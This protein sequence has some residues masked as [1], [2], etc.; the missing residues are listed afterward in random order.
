[1]STQTDVPDAHRDIG[2]RWNL[3]KLQSR[4]YILTSAT[5]TRG[6]QYKVLCGIRSGQLREDDLYQLM[7]RTMDS[8][9]ITTLETVLSLVA[10]QLI[11]PIDLKQDLGSADAEL[12]E[13]SNSAGGRPANP[14]E[15]SPA[16]SESSQ[17]VPI[18][19]LEVLESASERLDVTV[20]SAASLNPQTDYWISRTPTAGL[21]KL[22]RTGRCP[23]W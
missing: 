13:A 16:E 23:C 7:G 11:E 3:N 22:H 10:K 1:M 9:P 4:E 15:V 5:I 19:G 2:G 21:R 14:E 17:P 8:Y 20:S 18:D 6:M 12:A